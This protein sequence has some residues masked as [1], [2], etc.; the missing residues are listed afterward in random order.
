MHFF[1]CLHFIEAKK[2]LFCFNE[3]MRKEKIFPFA[4]ASAL[5]FFDISI[6]ICLCGVGNSSGIDSQ[7]LLPPKPKFSTCALQCASLVAHYNTGSH[8]SGIAAPQKQPRTNVDELHFV[9]LKEP[10]SSKIYSPPTF[11]SRRNKTGLALAHRWETPFPA[12]KRCFLVPPVSLL[13]SFV[14]LAELLFC[15]NFVGLMNQH[16]CFLNKNKSKFNQKL[17]ICL[18]VQ[19]NNWS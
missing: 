9:S 4:F 7:H 8:D 2:I 12:A 11:F 10:Q 13:V 15:W 19:S 17:F 18:S 3:L 1:F 6:W 5:F 14:I 16:I